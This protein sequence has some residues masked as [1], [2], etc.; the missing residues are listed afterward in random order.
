VL[1]LA[2]DT[3]SSTELSRSV[4]VHLSLSV[5]SRFIQTSKDVHEANEQKETP[6][7]VEYLAYKENDSGVKMEDGEYVCS[8]GK[9]EVYQYNADYDTGLLYGGGYEL[10]TS[11]G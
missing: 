2:L 9:D 4:Q 5:F 1:R 7:D 10:H 3:R 6:D 11:G 8:D